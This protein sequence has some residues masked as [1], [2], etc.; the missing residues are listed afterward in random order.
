M[1][2]IPLLRATLVCFLGRSLL[3]THLITNRDDPFA[4]GLFL[5]EIYCFAYDRRRGHAFHTCAYGVVIFTSWKP[6]P[7]RNVARFKA[8]RSLGGAFFL[9]GSLPF[10]TLRRSTGIRIGKNEPLRTYHH[11]Q[12]IHS[13]YSTSHSHSRSYPFRSL[14]VCLYLTPCIL[15]RTPIH[16]SVVHSL[17]P[18]PAVH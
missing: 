18:N 16:A 10:I 5:P 11:G 15:V 12:Y 17:I 14:F 3:F 4:H 13:T 6:I 7:F 1:F 9:V 8:S 2:L